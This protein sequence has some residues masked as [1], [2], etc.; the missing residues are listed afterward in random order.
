MISPQGLRAVLV[1]EPWLDHYRLYLGGTGANHFM[2]ERVEDGRIVY[3]QIARDEYE[4]SPLLTLSQD[5]V[6]ALAKALLSES[7]P[8]DATLDALKDARSVRDR[9]LSMMEARGIR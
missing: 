8:E 7:R 5:E 1:R 3:K 2:A 4:S 6:D 9:L